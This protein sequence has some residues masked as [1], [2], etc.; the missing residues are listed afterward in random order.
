MCPKLLKIAD[1]HLC[2]SNATDYPLLVTITTGLRF[3][4]LSTK[5][6]KFEIS[7]VITYFN[8]EFIFKKYLKGCNITVLYFLKVITH[9]E[10]DFFVRRIT[11]RNPVLDLRWI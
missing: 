8:Y 3:I 6:C 4:I 1:I 9:F 11:N 5:K 2:R 10:F 7:M